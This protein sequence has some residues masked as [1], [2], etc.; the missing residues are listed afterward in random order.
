M[1]FCTG[2]TRAPAAN[3]VRAH[4]PD[5][6]GTASPTQRTRTAGYSTHQAAVSDVDSSCDVIYSL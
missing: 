1:V 6:G 5:A 4:L 3:D 2:D